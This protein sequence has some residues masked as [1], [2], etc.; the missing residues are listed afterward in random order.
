M[1]P[2]NEDGLENGKEP[3]PPQGLFHCR[4]HEGLPPVPYTDEHFEEDHG[5]STANQLRRRCRG[6]NCSKCQ[7]TRTRDEFNL[8]KKLHQQE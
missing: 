4:Q 5:G 1:Q 7:A 6:T 2:Q 8:F 3:H